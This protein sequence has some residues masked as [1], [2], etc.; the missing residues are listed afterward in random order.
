MSDER[1][2]AARLAALLRLGFLAVLGACT[3]PAPT[4]MAEPT[5]GSAAPPVSPES[6]H[7]PTTQAAPTPVPVQAQAPPQEAPA[8]GPAVAGSGPQT[9]PAPAGSSG[10]APASRP[11]FDVRPAMVR[12]PAGEELTHAGCE[13]PDYIMHCAPKRKP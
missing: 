7:T 5:R 12:C 9:G 2:R 8:P 13:G 11:C 6:G 4:P 1:T 3:T 10:A